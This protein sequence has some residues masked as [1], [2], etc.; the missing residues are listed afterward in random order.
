MDWPFVGR[1]KLLSSILQTFRERSHPGVLLVGAAGVGKTRLAHEAAS[2]WQR[3]GGTVTWLAASEALRDRPFG[4]FTGSLRPVGGDALASMDRLATAVR[5]AGLRPVLVVD[6]VPRT[7][8]LT[9]VLIAR[10]IREPTVGV[11]LTARG[12]E[13]LPLPLDALW[14]EGTLHRIDVGGL[15][16]SEFETF[17]RA[18]LGGPVETS[19]LA[20]L[21]KVSEGNALYA[22]LTIEGDH[23]AGRLV[24]AHGT[25]RWREPSKLSAALADVLDRRIGEAL[26][27]GEW[28][29]DAADVLA[30]AEPLEVG[31]LSALAGARTV[32]RLE[33]LGMVQVDTTDGTTWCR[34]AHP[35][36]GE[37]LRTQM[38]S[39]R[40][41]R[42]S[43][44]LVD[45]VQ[46]TAAPVD[47]GRLLGFILDAGRPV[48]PRMAQ[49]AASAAL[50]RLDL[51]GGI[52]FARAAIDAGAGFGAHLDLV[53][54]LSWSNC[55]EEAAAWADDL[56]EASSSPMERVFA[57]QVLAGNA[58]FVLGEPK[59]ALRLLEEQLALV[60]D[61]DAA[62]RELQAMQAWFE[63]FMARPGRGL[64]LAR[65]AS[66]GMPLGAI[67]A[68]SALAAETYAG[69]LRAD[70]DPA[71]PAFGLQDEVSTP[72]LSSLQFAILEGQLYAVN[73]AGDLTS[74]DRVL[75]LIPAGVHLDLSF[76]G[77]IS[78]ALRGFTQFFRGDVTTA[79]STLQETAASLRAY[80][81]TG[82]AFLAALHLT[83]ALALAG[84]ATDARTAWD[85][86]LALQ[87]PGFVYRGPDVMLTDAW[88]AAAGGEISR[89]IDVAREAAQRAATTG[90]YGP[91]TLCLHAAVRLGDSTAASRLSELAAATMGPRAPLAARH[92]RAL[93]DRDAVALQAV[94]REFYRRQDLA[95][96][97][98]AEVHALIILRSDGLS[99]AALTSQSRLSAIT[100]ATGLRTPTLTS[101]RFGAV[102]SRREYEVVALAARGLTNRDIAGRLVL[103][104]RT[105]E[106]H[107]YRAAQKLGV[108]HRREFA[109][110]LGRPDTTNA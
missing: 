28:L 98:D 23:D 105:V 67:G 68:T 57:A 49:E 85:Q 40:M 84:R 93:A 82:W 107:V 48:D 86:C 59:A 42:L 110:L 9:A 52:R 30:L 72:A 65:E 58:F 87:H 37:L 83:Q 78:R 14:L 24:Q 55:G 44:D 96:A 25:W 62:T 13:S 4:V 81:R 108:S 39:L 99:G 69:A 63:T 36:V 66:R 74:A 46:R 19:G 94:S 5:K 75:A 12:G 102:L 27:T 2:V 6:D 79:A 31:V 71:D 61:D 29:R 91:E 80:D 103:S 22:R 35:L 11:L 95:A 21:R 106:G 50:N 38:G 32:E 1:T 89:A 101:T 88:V 53:F 60:G 16:E 43:G 33:D 45:A 54:A 15:N 97:L 90:M 8:Y 92:A 18:A 20:R 51:A 3:L 70:V 26:G 64:E 104:V 109:A 77:D 47:P 41:R 7:D 34:T 10:M 17:V 76:F 73:V 56:L 100:A